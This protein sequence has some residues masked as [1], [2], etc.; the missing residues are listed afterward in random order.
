MGNAN[1]ELAGLEPMLAKLNAVETILAE[2]A[3]PTKEVLD[4]LKERLQKYPPPPP[5]STYT[6]TGNLGN[7]WEQVIVLSGNALTAK[8]Q[9]LIGY[10]QWVQD[11]IK[12]A[13]VHQGRW[14]TIQSVADDSEEEAV[15]IYS[16]FLQELI[17][18]Q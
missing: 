7:S 14:Q 6:R 15:A 12:Q 8:V 4:L 10:G 2:L 17:N 3:V 1:L 13:P 18:R 16:Q 5:N 9:S 11:Q